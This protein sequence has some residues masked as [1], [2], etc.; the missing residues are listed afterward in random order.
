MVSSLSIVSYV[1]AATMTVTCVRNIAVGYVKE[2]FQV[3]HGLGKKEWLRLLTVC[4]LLICT[5]FGAFLGL[6][7][8]VGGPAAKVLQFSWV[9]L[10]ASPTE[11]KQ[12]ANLIVAAGTS[13]PYFGLVFLALLF[14]NLPGMARSE[15]EMF[16]EKTKSWRDGI[17]RSIAFGL[18]HC[19]VGVPVAVGLALTIPGLWFTQ[20]FFWGGVDRSTRVHAVYNM[21]MIPAIAVSVILSTVHR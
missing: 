4:P 8:K 7:Y 12:G 18:F 1:V 19:I 17:P 3:F 10:L 13:I 5:M 21:L 20:E 14:F 16:R 15:E 11:N 2:D 9:S 6:Y